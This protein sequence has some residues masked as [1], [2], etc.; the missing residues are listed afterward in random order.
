MSKHT[1]FLRLPAALVV[2]ACLHSG[3]ASGQ[4]PAEEGPV[5][6]ETL[7]GDSAGDRAPQPDR[8][9][10]SPPTKPSRL[11][12]HRADGEANEEM[13][14]ELTR[15]IASEPMPQQVLQRVEGFLKLRSGDLSRIRTRARVRAA[16]P[17]LAV[18]GRLTQ[19]D[20][21]RDSTQLPSPVFVDER[22]DTRD[23]SVNVGVLWDLRDAAFTGAEIDVYSVADLRRRILT[24]ASRVYLARRLMQIDLHLETLTLRRR[25][26]IEARI[27][28]YTASL[29]AVTGGWF[30][31]AIRSRASSN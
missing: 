23:V 27:A 2:G 3:I 10:K 15:L 29:D 14:P 12:D 16:A 26:Q 25:L 13:P 31:E 30:S 17:L 11:P 4:A 7:D 5:R 18:G 9:T 19:I 28:D 8:G 1:W 21:L 22:T 24:E 6:G 20:G